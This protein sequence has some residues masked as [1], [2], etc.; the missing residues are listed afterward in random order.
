[1]AQ[2]QLVYIVLLSAIIVTWC[3]VSAMGIYVCCVKRDNPHD[4]ARIQPAT[5]F[6]VRND[7]SRQNPETIDSVYV[8][9]P[10]QSD[11]VCLGV[12]QQTRC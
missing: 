3:V 2:T 8:V 5:S 11:D 4:V 10:D 9:H 12:Q 7:E 6:T 1:M